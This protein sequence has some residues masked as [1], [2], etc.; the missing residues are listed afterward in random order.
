MD[1]L[2]ADFLVAERA[3]HNVALAVRHCPPVVG[4]LADPIVEAGRVEAVVVMEGVCSVVE[5]VQTD[6]AVVAI[7]LA[8]L[9]TLIFLLL[10]LLFASA[11]LA[12]SC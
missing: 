10:P 9:V 8:I 4:T 1:T 7:V 6:A 5:W 11:P 2:A 12:A 3:G